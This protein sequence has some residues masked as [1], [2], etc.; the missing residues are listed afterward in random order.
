M[1]QVEKIIKFTLD[2]YS[3]IE[4]CLVLDILALSEINDDHE[5]DDRI[6]GLQSILKKIEVVKN[7][8]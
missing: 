8:D 6:S 5:Y 1:K 7:D 4:S 2:E 3:L